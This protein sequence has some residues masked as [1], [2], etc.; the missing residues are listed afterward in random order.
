M[1]DSLFMHTLSF[2]FFHFSFHFGS[3]GYV[4][5]MISWEKLHKILAGCGM[6]YPREDEFQK[7]LVVCSFH[8]NPFDDASSQADLMAAEEAAL[9]ED[10]PRYLDPVLQ[11]SSIEPLYSARTV[12]KDPLWHG[13]GTTVCFWKCYAGLG[14]QTID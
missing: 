7:S 6:N 8:I 2:F 11:A 14:P 13:H 12:G 5:H 9:L 3:T 4:Q 10:S 1:C